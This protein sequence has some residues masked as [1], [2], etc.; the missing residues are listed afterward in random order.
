MANNQMVNFNTQDV[1]NTYRRNQYAQAL[2]ERMNAPIPV[3]TFQGFQAPVSP[4]AG[5][6][7][8]L[9]IYSVYQN[10]KNQEKQ[11]QDEKAAA[12][13]KAQKLIDTQNE[14]ATEFGNQFNPVL[15]EKMIGGNTSFTPTQYANA[16]NA[17]GNP[18]E[19]T[20]ASDMLNGEPTTYGRNEGTLQTTS[21]PRTREE[22][23]R[24]ESQG[25]GSNNLGM[26]RIAQYNRDSRV[27]DET[28]KAAIEAATLERGKGINI[29]GQLV[30]AFSGDRIGAQIPEQQKSPT[31]SIT[32]DNKTGQS[33][34]KEA[35]NL[36]SISAVKAEGATAQLNSINNILRATDDN[37]IF[38]GITGGIGLR[39]AQF[40]DMIGVGGKDNAEKIINTRATIQGLAQM[41]LAGRKEMKGEGAITQSESD[42]AEKA[43][44]GDISDLTIP[45]IQQIAR[46]S[47]RI[48][49][50][51]LAQHDRKLTM[52]KNNPLHRELAGYYE[53]AESPLSY[54]MKKDRLPVKTPTGA[55]VENWE[56][57]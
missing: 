35:A 25:A 36:M 48:A 34:G 44:S 42:L 33:L 53:P 30:N 37:K 20:Q 15:T 12:E 6:A 2:Q 46:T 3:N 18:Q 51:N 26:N 21:T 39:L 47:E 50:F 19:P 52:M 24:L 54:I 23:M 57:K 5:I 28:A 49:R 7:K 55:T 40:A 1:A 10:E 45:E 9:D 22:I 43:V 31:T 41:T 14:Q 4:A 17:Y 16:I 56:K 13:Q 8:A 29:N 38:S 27:A 32:I 11:Y